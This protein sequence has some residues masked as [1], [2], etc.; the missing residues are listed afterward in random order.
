[1]TDYTVY[2]DL[3]M[4]TSVYLVGNGGLLAQTTTQKNFVFVSL[5]IY[6]FIV[7]KRKIKK[8]SRSCPCLSGCFHSALS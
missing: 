3:V 2:Q 4:D 1:M 8:S 7:L 6:V 5:F